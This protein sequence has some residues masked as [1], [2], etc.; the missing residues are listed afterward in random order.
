MLILVSCTSSRH[1]YAFRNSG[2]ALHTYEQFLS[3]ARSMRRA[4]AQELTSLIRSWQELGDTVYHFIGKDPAFTAHTALSDSY[5]SLH[6]SIRVEVM[7]L[8]SEGSHS[9]HDVLHIK[10]STSIYRDEREVLPVLKEC[11]RFEETLDSLPCYSL[12][13]KETLLLYRS[14]LEEVGRGGID[15]LDDLRQRLKEEDRIFRTYLSHLDEYSDE[16]LTDITKATEAMCAGIYRNV[17]EGKLMAMETVVQMALRTNRR[18]LQN[19]WACIEAVKGTDGLDTDQRSAFFWM[20]IQ[21]FIS[22]DSFGMSVLSDGQL[23]Q[24]DSLITEIERLD[25]KGKLGEH[26]DIAGLCELILKLYITSI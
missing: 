13:K 21:P 6:D 22:I 23:Q 26:K 2:E 3:D 12:G 20:M 9:L 14:F 8:A 7:R 19:A 1:D 5:D 25:S 15:S 10:Y 11:R 4:S 18:L 24:L 17:S 16:S